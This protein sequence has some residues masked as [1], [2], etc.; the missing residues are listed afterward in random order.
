MDQYLQLVYD[1]TETA[2]RKT[3]TQCHHVIPIFCYRST[4]NGEK[5]TALKKIAEADEFNFTVNMTFSQ[6]VKAHVLLLSCLLNEMLIE[7]DWWSI[8]SLLR[9][10]KQLDIKV[11]KNLADYDF[12]YLQVYYQQFRAAKLKHP[13]V[14]KKEQAKQTKTNTRPLI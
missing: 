13:K 1:C 7:A 11:S 3:E 5:R 8:K 6:H 4:V 2:Y 14:K 12:D 10:V 9:F